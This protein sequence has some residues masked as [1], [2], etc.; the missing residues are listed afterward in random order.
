MFSL[1]TYYLWDAQHLQVWHV[2]DNQLH[3]MMAEHDPYCLGADF[4]RDIN[5]NSRWANYDALGRLVQGSFSGTEGQ[6]DQ[7]VGFGYTGEYS[8]TIKD[9]A[10]AL[11]DPKAAIQKVA[12]AWFHEA[13][14]WMGT[15]TP[16]HLSRAGVAGDELAPLWRHL[17]ARRWIT[18]DGR[19]RERLREAVLQGTPGLPHATALRDALETVPRK[20][21]HWAELVADRYSTDADAS[22]MQVRITVTSLNGAGGVFQRAIKAEPG[23]SHV[24]DG[25]GG[26]VLEGE[27]PV[28]RHSEARWII[29]DR[30]LHIQGELPNVVF[31]PCYLDSADPLGH[32]ILSLPHHRHGYDARRRLVRALAD[33]RERRTRFHAWHREDED[34][35]DTAAAGLRKGEPRA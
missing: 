15:L 35:N 17:L 6:A 19:V 28:I 32:D 11:A 10:G 8:S 5:G 1:A 34:E 29:R 23:D 14:S 27:T 30:V 25:K 26:L 9:V 22:A 33:G 21:P 7:N 13:G 3:V 20:P 4:V 12:R 16:A 18:R 31:L 24:A 2:S